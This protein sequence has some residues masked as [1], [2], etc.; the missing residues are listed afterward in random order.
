MSGS[1]GA[2]RVERWFASR[3]WS[4]H[5]FQRET[6]ALH[7]AGRAALV[8][9]PTGSGKTLAAWLGPVI[10]ALD[11]PGPV[12]APT[13]PRVLWITPLRAL[14]AD[15]RGHLQSAADALGLAWRVELRTGDTASSVRARQRA[16]PPHALVTTPESLSVLLSYAES[17]PWLAAVRTVVV[18]EWHELLGSKRGVQLELALARLR[19]LSPGLRTLG[20]SATIAN[21]A[22]AARVLAGP[23]GDPA[24]VRAPD[25]RDT[26]IDS[27][28][29]STIER[30]PWAGHL[31][32]RLLAPVLESLEAAATTLLFTNT[33]SQAETWY[34]AIVDARPEWLDRV[35]IHHGS[36]ARD[37]RARIEDG[38]RAGALKCVVCTSSLDLGVDFATVEQVLQVGS[39]KGIARLLQRAGRS[40]HRP[41]AA[42][43]VLC[44]PTHALEL[45]EVAAARRAALDGRVE[46]RRPLVRCLDVLAQHLV[47][48]AA[49][50]GFAADALLREVRGT[51]AYATLS[52]EEWAWTLDFVTRGGQALSAY[53]Q[54]RRVAL[55]DGLYR[56]PEP[57]LA[58]LHRTQIGTITSDG[59]LELRWVGGGSL[60]T[61]EEAFVARQKPGDAFVFAGRVVQLVRVRG[62]VGYVRLATK[63]SRATPR[64][65]GGR[66]PLSTELADALLD[67][68]A[69]RPASSTDPASAPDA[70]V[71]DAEPELRLLRPLF[72]LQARWSRL[73]SHRELLAERL[74]T[75]HGHHLFVYPFAG[76]A[77]HEGLATLVAHR[78][79][80]ERPA[81]F[82]LSFNDYGF[83]LLS[84]EPIGIDAQGLARALAPDGLVDAL[85]AAVNVSEVARRQFR[86]IARIAGLVLQGL[87]GRAKTTRQLQ[88]SSGLVY[89]V[90]VRYDPDNRLVAQATREV[91]EGQLE[92][93]RLRECLENLAG[94]PVAL[95]EPPRLTPL[96]FPLWAEALQSQVV[97]TEDWETRVL[98]MVETLERAAGDA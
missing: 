8:N 92:A 90:L 40:Q 63:R 52:D 65:S 51:H 21:L 31:G 67:V 88:A 81:T 38:L 47:T 30:F 56:V 12:A 54:Y 77:V 17:G 43:R 97:S 85:V 72:D 49:G 89:D 66:M 95:V 14:A 19:A 35:A 2:S 13:G 79:S 1:N 80:R 25:P 37:V 7:A 68:L 34:R 94:R 58:R 44:V 70:A 15:L 23:A 48:L 26:R 9:A 33:R 57:R 42:S 91:L 82:T 53:P 55:V 76:R 24:I 6:W 5:P 78:L 27:I 45:A 20:L 18:D 75:R 59:T 73:P 86:D 98:R 87:P 50:P 62:M 4:V 10:E 16:K 32:L 74:R 93:A 22:E 11:E 64:W 69:S 46:A 83:E 96:A 29:P 61:I 36:I 60:G 71:V 28:R 84:P 39:P 3:G 41:G